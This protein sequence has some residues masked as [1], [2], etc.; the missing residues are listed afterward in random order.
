[1]STLHNQP[2]R[3]SSHYNDVIIS[4]VASEITSLASV[5]S[6][7]CYSNAENVSIWWRHHDNAFRR[8]HFVAFKPKFDFHWFRSVKSMLQQ[9]FICW[10][11]TFKLMSSLDAFTDNSSQMSHCLSYLIHEKLCVLFYLNL[12]LSGQ[13][14]S[15][16]GLTQSISWLLIPW[17]LA[18]HD[19]QQS[20]YC[21]RKLGRSLSY[22]RRGFNFVCHVSVEDGNS[23]YK[24]L[25]KNLVHK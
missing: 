17:L 22:M 8:P 18:S 23:K 12:T 13:G 5:Y 11:D 7:V 14:L 4:A 25:L 15:Y 24:F 6:T 16:P 19:H 2:R 9:I 1:M 20:W 21:R 3:V 10:C